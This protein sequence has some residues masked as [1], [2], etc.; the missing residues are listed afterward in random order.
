MSPALIPPYFR[1][2]SGCTECG[3]TGYHGRL[4]IFELLTLDDSIQQRIIEGAG[5]IDI[6][7]EA[8]AEGMISLRMDGLEKVQQGITTYEEVLRVTR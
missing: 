3:G 8:L 2:G 1:K 4:G 5:R 7:N 6:I